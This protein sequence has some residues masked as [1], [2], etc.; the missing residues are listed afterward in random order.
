VVE[1]L[2]TSVEQGFTAR[3]TF[4]KL[5][6]LRGPQARLWNKNLILSGKYMSSIKIKIST[7]HWLNDAD[8]K[9]D[10]VLRENP[11][12]VHHKIRNI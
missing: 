5:Q 3:G 10:D 2:Y 7:A 4:E 9:K 11:V 12:L 8:R 1:T 6:T